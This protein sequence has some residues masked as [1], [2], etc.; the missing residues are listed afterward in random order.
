MSA[1]LRVR[2]LRKLSDC[3]WLYNSYPEFSDTI[4][5][6]EICLK[7]PAGGEPQALSNTPPD[8]GLVTRRDRCLVRRL[9]KAGARVVLEQLLVAHVAD[10]SV[11]GAMP[12]Q[13]A[14]Q[15]EIGYQKMQLGK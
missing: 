8:V 3:K 9:K 6:E 15:P 1:V 4:K 5:R 13:R 10:Q 12:D 14:Q 7:T 2:F 11:G